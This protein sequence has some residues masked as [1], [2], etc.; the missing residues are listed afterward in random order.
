MDEI[1]NSVSG[2]SGNYFSLFKKKNVLKKL[3]LL[4]LNIKITFSI[5]SLNYY[6]TDNIV[7]ENVF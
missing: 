2:F 5:F 1:L 4:V 7:L 6:Y 3:K